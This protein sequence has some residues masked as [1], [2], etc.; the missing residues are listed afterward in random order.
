[1]ALQQNPDYDATYFFNL[2]ILHGKLGQPG[3][4]V[5]YLEKSNQL[6][7]HDPDTQ[8]NLRVA[9]KALSDHLV[10]TGSQVSV[11]SASTSLER[12]SD[13][14]QG[15]EVLG[16]TG[17]VTV[18]VSLLWIRAYLKTRNL[19]KTFLK[20]SGWF[21]V[22]ALVLVVAFY[23]VYRTGSLTPAA[24][25]VNRELLRSGPGLTFPEIMSVDS[26]IKVRMV[27]SALNVNENE[28]WQKVRYK[29]DQTAWL[30]SSSLLP[31]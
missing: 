8:R 28:S 27:G 15:E 25:L 29:G 7:P 3:L 5:A 26:G 18:I 1:E 21:G 13:R 12:F 23:A 16:I 30:P 6:R 24:V 2:G 4:A 17:L 31:L 9:R 20:P 22:L 11:D 19:T 14:I 10:N